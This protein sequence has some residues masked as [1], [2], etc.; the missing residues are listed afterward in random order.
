MAK[1]PRS[2]PRGQ[3]SRRPDIDYGRPPRDIDYGRPPGQLPV[4]R[5]GSSMVPRDG[6]YGGAASDNRK[7]TPHRYS[8]VH[9]ASGSSSYENWKRQ[10]KSGRKNLRYRRS[11]YRRGSKRFRWG[12]LFSMVFLA[13]IIVFLGSFAF[14]ANFRDAIVAGVYTF[15]YNHT[16]DDPKLSGD[17]TNAET[18]SQEIIYTSIEM[19]KSDIDKGDLI[20]VNNDYDYD[21]EANA[22]SIHLVNINE[23]KCNA[24]SAF[25][26]DLQVGSVMINALNKLFT[27]FE[28]ATGNDSVCV[29]SAYR[30]LEYQE[31]LYKNKV[32]DV[33]Q[34]KADEWAALPGFSEHH[35][36]LAVDIGIAAPGGGAETFR[37]DGDYAWVVENCYKYGLVNRYDETKRD[38]TGIMDEPWHYRYVGIP[39][40]Q[41]MYSENLCLEEYI[42]SLKYYSYKGEHLKVSAANG[43]DYEIYYV[44]GKFRS[45]VPVPKNYEYTISGNNVD[46]FV[47]TVDMSTYSSGSEEQQE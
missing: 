23:Y 13:A 7:S 45:G 21:F 38:I 5:G 14:S 43:K 34:S 28:N 27:D 20:L 39:H 37:K 6:F 18:E 4:V 2:R 22:E 30:N 42:D 19:K 47:V 40:A 3:R 9:N 33:G 36:G 10:Q 46:G 29:I 12:R 41:V 16:H 11:N 25:N 15:A 17:I 8:K 1:A 44:N 26:N 24:Y 31:N 35:T 32:S